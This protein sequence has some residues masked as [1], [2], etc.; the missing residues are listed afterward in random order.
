VAGLGFATTAFDISPTAVREATGRHPGSAVRYV[1]ADLLDPPASWIRAYDLVVEVH[2]VQALPEPPRRAA[3]INV[4]RLVAP[5]GT[6]LTV[7][8]RDPDGTAGRPPPWPLTRAE[9]AVY[10][11]DGLT[12]AAVDAL[13]GRWRAEF[14]RPA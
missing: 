9:I 13:P 7:S 14:I 2:T 10:A 1:T 12:E 11:T 6:L 3:I 8:Y 4:G 5:G